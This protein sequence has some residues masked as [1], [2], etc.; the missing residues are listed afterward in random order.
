[1]C[2]DEVEDLTDSTVLAQKVLSCVARAGQRFGVGHI[3]EV[4]QGADT[5]AIRRLGHQN[6]S[7]YGLLKDL[8]QKTLQSLVYQLI[9]QGLL[10]R[11]AGDR[12]T[13]QLND[14]SLAVLRGQ[15]EV[16]L[17]QPKNKASKAAAK[18]AGAEPSLDGVD[19]GLLGHLRALRRGWAQQKG[20]PAFVIFH[21][22]T[23]LELARV[24]PT[25]PQM[26]HLIHGLGEKK[27]ADFGAAL[28][29]TIQGYCAQHQLTHDQT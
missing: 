8:P 13:L 29:G 7:T 15:R 23:L 6:L 10:S 20:V 25:T 11:T 14:G 18:A 2:L 5:Q 27:R 24:R 17:V 12:P 9:D 16:R 22:T 4:L 28:L 26:L 19:A 1:V 21:D 3:V